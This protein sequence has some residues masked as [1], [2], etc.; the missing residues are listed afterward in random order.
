MVAR[1]DD[2]PRSVSERTLERLREVQFALRAEYFAA[3][4]DPWIIGYSGGKDSTLLVQLVFEMLLDLAPG[5]RM[6]ERRN[7]R[8]AL[9]GNGE[10][11]TVA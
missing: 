10:P 8:I 9:M 7:G 1:M 11:S 3:N 2:E 6:L 5:D 4:K